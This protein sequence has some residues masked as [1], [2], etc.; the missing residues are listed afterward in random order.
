MGETRDAH[1][2]L[3][4]K[5]REGDCSEDSDIDARIILQLIFEKWDGGYG[6]D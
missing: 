1:R 3:V 6:L 5:P 4:G 2:V